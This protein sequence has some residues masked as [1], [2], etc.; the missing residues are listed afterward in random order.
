MRCCNAENRVRPAQVA[1]DFLET[2]QEALQR[3]GADGDVGANLHIP[4]AQFAGH[5]LYTLFLL[6]VLHPQQIV[7]QQL[8]KTA[9]DFTDAVTRYRAPSQSTGVNPLLDGDMRFRFELQIALAGITAIVVFQGTLNVD[10]MR[11]VS[12][13]QVA[14]IAVHC[15]HKIGERGHQ[16]HRQAPAKP[17]RL[18]RQFDRKV[19]ERAPVTGRF[20]NQQRLHQG[21]RLPAVFC[22]HYGRLHVR[23]LVHGKTIY[24]IVLCDCQ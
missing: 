12:F 7:G 18:L 21:R 19:S 8:A 11:I 5:N 13:N 22:R 20:T 2:S 3:A 14:V 15:P 6:R 10:G 16:A 23:Y 17:R 9:M 4:P 1:V 24:N